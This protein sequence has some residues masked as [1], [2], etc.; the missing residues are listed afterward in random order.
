MV[1]QSNMD[2]ITIRREE[3]PKKDEKTVPF[4]TTM[5]DET[6]DL[7]KQGSTHVVQLERKLK[8]RHLQMIAIGECCLPERLFLL[9][10]RFSEVEQ[11]EPAYSSAAEK[12]SHIRDQLAH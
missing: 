9:I 4:S 8:S 1:D 10:L 7:E 2:D 6:S 11:S 12:Q 3:S 5:S